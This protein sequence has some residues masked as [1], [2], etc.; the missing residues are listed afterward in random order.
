M[1]GNVDSPANLKN[2]GHTAD[3][4]GWMQ[5]DQGDTSAAFTVELVQNNVSGTGSGTYRPPQ[6]EWD[7]DVTASNGA[8]FNKGAAVANVSAVVSNGNGTTTVPWTTNLQID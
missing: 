3:V 2:G 1:H 7:I 6:T 4:D 5:W 8:T